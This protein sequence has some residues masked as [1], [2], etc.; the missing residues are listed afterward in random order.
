M[1]NFKEIIHCKIKFLF[2]S[3]K[4]TGK[5]KEIYIHKIKFSFLT[6]F[7]LIK[8]CDFILNELLEFNPWGPDTQMWP[9]VI[10]KQVR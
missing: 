9:K 1:M 8:T 5:K 2:V 6:F 10:L 7:V 3:K 4:R